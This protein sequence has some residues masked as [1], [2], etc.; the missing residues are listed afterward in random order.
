MLK[1]VFLIVLGLIF[2]KG[3]LAVNWP[4]PKP[5]ST[6]LSST[7]PSPSPTPV[8]FRDINVS[9]DLPGL[10]IRQTGI[11]GVGLNIYDEHGVGINIE[12]GDIRLSNALSGGGAIRMKDSKGIDQSTLFM[13]GDSLRLGN[14]VDG[15][16]TYIQRDAPAAGVPTGVYLFGGN[17]DQSEAD[18]VL[19]SLQASASRLKVNS[20]LLYMWARVWNNGENAI[21]S[22]DTQ[23]EASADGPAGT[24]EGIV[25]QW[26][27]EFDNEAPMMDFIM[28]GGP[29]YNIKVYQ[30]M[31]LSPM[32]QPAIPEEGMIIYNK[33]TH[34]LNFYNGTRWEEVLSQ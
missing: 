9:D 3:A 2:A 16:I 24:R 4:L 12:K 31:T 1:V 8:N 7:S 33:N 15:G 23:V 17:S 27:G 13:A 26:F 18:F 30:P 20:P 19:D 32:N 29:R 22:Y 6:P 11:L 5:S 28:N 14:P 21:L 10:N 34:K 25:H